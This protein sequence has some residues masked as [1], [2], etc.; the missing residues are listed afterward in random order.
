MGGP[1]ENVMTR[2][3]GGNTGGLQ[4]STLAIGLASAIGYL[5]TEDGK[6]DDLRE[7]AA[8]LAR[9]AETAA[10][11]LLALA[12]G[13][14]SCTQQDLRCREQPCPAQ[15]KPRS[16]PPRGRA[17][18]PG[19]RPAGGAARRVVLPR[20]ELP[21]TGRRRR[22]VRSGRIGELNVFQN[23]SATDSEARAIPT[24]WWWVIAALII[25]A[26]VPCFA[27]G[28]H[29]TNYG[30]TSYGRSR[31]LNKPAF[32]PRCL[33][34]APRQQS[35][36]GHFVDVLDRPRSRQLF[37]LS[38]SVGHCRNW[39]DPVVWPARSAVG[40]VRQPGGDRAQRRIRTC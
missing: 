18:S 16:R 15:R 5:G 25:T 28:G 22:P 24:G 12:A 40:T 31:R 3:I 36:S 20:L 35:L 29:R 34:P 27:C 33:Q 38:D 11:D 17:T 6:R 2:G 9:D 32:T 21:T 4:T 39:F 7:A 30:L 8:A 23:V 19:I 26:A 10:G 1:V 37:C 14:A 13:H